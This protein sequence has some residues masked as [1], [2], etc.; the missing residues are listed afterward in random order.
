MDPLPIISGVLTSIYGFLNAFAGFLQIKAKKIQTWSAWLMLGSGLLL[1][2]SGV[3][4]VLK[5]PSA[6]LFLAIGLI[7]IHLLAINNGFH[8][9]GRINIGHHLFRFVVSIILFGLAF[10]SRRY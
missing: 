4:L 7:S 3:I 5:L 2:G 1:L 9:Y 8:L 6:L 10:W